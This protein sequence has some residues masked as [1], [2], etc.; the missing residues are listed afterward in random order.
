MQRVGFMLKVKQEHIA[1]YKRHHE[2]VWP[3]MQAALTRAGWH[4]YSLFI[5]PDGL[6]F[7]YVEAAESFQQSL[8][9]MAKEP[10]NAQWQDFMAPF[11]EGIP[12]LHADKQMEQLEPYFFLP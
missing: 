8:D 7:G 2:N 5:R 9:N 4:N 11:F 6:I 3:E 12:G 10:I 1:E